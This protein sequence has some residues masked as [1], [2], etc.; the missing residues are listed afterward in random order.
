MKFTGLSVRF[1]PAD[2]SS[3]GGSKMLKSIDSGTFTNTSVATT[4]GALPTQ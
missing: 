3:V 2:N 4:V 1:F